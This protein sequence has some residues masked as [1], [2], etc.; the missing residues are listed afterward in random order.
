MGLQTFTSIVENKVYSD[1]CS[2]EKLECI[3]HV[4]KEWGRLRRL[5][6]HEVKNFLTGKPLCGRNRLQRR[7]RPSAKH[8]M[9]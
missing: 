9:V 3:G 2:V 1:H 8:I 7:N 5:K 6:R 4:M